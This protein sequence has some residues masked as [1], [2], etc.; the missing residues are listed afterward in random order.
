MNISYLSHYPSRLEAEYQVLVNNGGLNADENVRLQEICHVIEEI[1][2]LT[3]SSD[4]RNER[5]NEIDAGES[6][7]KY[8]LYPHSDEW[9]RNRKDAQEVFLTL[10]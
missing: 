9:R 8:R 6:M 2:R 1:D 4:V 5:L 10:G 3:L 7:R